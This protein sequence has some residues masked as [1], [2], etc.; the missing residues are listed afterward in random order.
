VIRGLHFQINPYAQ[1]KL[2]RVLEDSRCCCRFTQKIIYFWKHF[3]VLLSAENN[4][5]LMVPHGFAHGFAV[6]SATASVIYKVDQVYN[7]RK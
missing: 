4:K 5:Q 2:V 6:L 7:K 3:S 1:A